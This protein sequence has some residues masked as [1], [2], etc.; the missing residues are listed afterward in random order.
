MTSSQDSQ[1][2]RPLDRI[3]REA[4]AWFTRMNGEPSAA[5]RQDFER[6]RNADPFHDKAYRQAVAIWAAA[7]GPSERIA[8]EEAGKLGVYLD[9]I[10]KA[11]KRRHRINAGIATCSVLLVLILGANLWLNHPDMLQN[12][13]ADHVTERGE[14]RMIMLADGTSVLLDAGSAL[15]EKFDAVGRRVELLRGAAYF[16]VASSDIPFIVRARTGETRVTGTAFSV[17]IAEDVVVT[18]E[19]GVVSVTAE[20]A[21][22][23]AMLD[24]G[25]SVSYGET[26]LGTVKQ[27]LVDE[28]LAWRDGRLIFDDARLDEVVSHI[29]RYRSGRVV[30][31]GSSL[32]AYRVSGNLP[33]DDSDAALASLQATVGFRMNSVGGLVV[34]GPDRS[35]DN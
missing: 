1:P 15:S 26:G 35:V 11:R 29:G 14:R 7:D 16:D 10:A 3:E 24:P 21:A 31:L 8:E 6:W 23:Q 22:G 27:V 20:A 34:I 18:L 13:M 5:D 4:I 33:L 30:I 12:L 28:T 9:A 25:Q 17:E 19:R 32:A 2:Q